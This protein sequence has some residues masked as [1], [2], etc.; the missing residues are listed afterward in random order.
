MMG[1]Y[2]PNFKRLHPSLFRGK[3]NFEHLLSEEGRR[4]YGL[5]Q[6]FNLLR[7][8]GVSAKKAAR[9]LES[10]TATVYRYKK[11]LASGEYKNL[12]PKSRGPLRKRKPQWDY[13]FEQRVLQLRQQ[14]PMW[15]KH[16]L[17]VLLAREG[18]KTSVSTVGRILKKLMNRGA[19][20]SVFDLCR[21]LRK[22]KKIIRKHATRMPKGFKAKEPGDLVQL[23]HMSVTNDTF[24]PIKHFGAQDTISK[25]G[26]A[27]VFKRATARNAAEFLDTVIDE[28]PF[29]IKAFQVD[30]GSEFK[31]DFEEACALKGIPLYVLPPQSPKLNGDIERNNGTWRYEFYWLQEDLPSQLELLRPIVYEHQEVY[32]KIRPHQSLNYLTPYEY[33]EKQQAQKVA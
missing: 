24:E 30:G 6:R 27:D 5:I 3:G 32:N 22:R 18:R 23:D 13:S 33:L 10:S 1:V 11:L 29:E 12:E 14:Y 31:R 17:Q 28:M 26:V 9:A 19:V 7:A 15:S 20:L 16:K 4:R 25:A 2:L 8:E 21:P